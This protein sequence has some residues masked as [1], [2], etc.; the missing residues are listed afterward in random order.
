MVGL[1]DFSVVGNIAYLSSLDMAIPKVELKWEIYILSTIHN[2]ISTFA[3]KRTQTDARWLFG[4][5]QRNPQL[6]F[7]A[8]QI[9]IELVNSSYLYGSPMTK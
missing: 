2:N 7:S 4:R 8:F 3:Q 6:T 5:L 9:F 1:L